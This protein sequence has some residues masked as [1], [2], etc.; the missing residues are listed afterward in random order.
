MKSISKNKLF[1]ILLLFIILISSFSKVFAYDTVCENG[2]TYTFSDKI[3]DYLKTTEYFNENYTCIGFLWN[4]QKYYVFFYEN[5]ADLKVHFYRVNGVRWEFYTSSGAKGVHMTFDTSGNYLDTI[6]GVGN[7]TDGYKFW[8]WFGG[9]VTSNNIL[10][11]NGKIY[12]SDSNLF[13][14]MPPPI[15]E[16]ITI[17]E[18]AKVEELPEVIVK[19]MKTII[20]IGLKILSMV[21]IIFL[22]RLVISQVI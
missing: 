16:E 22:V 3:V 20:P 15:V 2:T 18:I 8:D 7:V 21:L 4:N 19:T 9:A 1:T 11:A 10:L 12:G 17:T 14:Q 5:T 13:F 6:N